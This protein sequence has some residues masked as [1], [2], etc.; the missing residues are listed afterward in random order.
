M[1]TLIP[2]APAGAL[3]GSGF[4]NDWIEKIRFLVNNLS[5]GNIDHQSL[6]NLQ[7]GNSTERYHLTSA[8]AALFG[9]GAAT[10]VLHGGASPAWAAVS[11]TADVTG[12]LPV[13]NGGTGVTA[14]SSLTAN[15]SASIGL[16]AVNGTASTFMRSDA[17]PALSQSIAPTWT[18]NH[19]FNPSSGHTR[20]DAGSLLVGT[21]TSVY[22]TSGRGV[23]EINGSS[24]AVW[25]LK[26]GD[27]EKGYI[28]VNS[29]NTSV[30]AFNSNQLRLGTAGA[31][32]LI[33]AVSNG[34]V[35]LNATSW[36]TSAVNVLSIANGTAPT[37]SPAG[38][39]QLYVES[40]ALKYRGSSGTVTTVAAA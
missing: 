22:A 19:I 32:V 25:A 14:L 15:P 12:T 33:F 20:I 17:A 34:N 11:L 8:Q 4:W 37:S 24:S 40:G 6:L 23:A 27:V 10:K 21:S 39:G 36:G 7:G 38:L 5:A 30:Q 29:T 13:G 1:A 18:G 31:D 26:V 9:G 3:P 28:F 35:G 2:P 16:S